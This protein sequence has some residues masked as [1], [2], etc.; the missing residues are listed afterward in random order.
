MYSR[1]HRH[2]SRDCGLIRMSQESNAALPLTNTVIVKI[3]GHSIDAQISFNYQLAPQTVIG[4][5]VIRERNKLARPV[6]KLMFTNRKETMEV[7]LASGA[8]FEAISVRGGTKIGE[9]SYSRKISIIP[10]HQPVTIV[11]K[12][13]P[14]T[15]LIFPI[16][17]FP[18][19]FGN[20][21]K[22]INHGA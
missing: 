4:E 16:L 17:N 2:I 7:V 21:S 19:I 15:E 5:M 12:E 14:L 9:D 22:Q 11:D 8:R 10:A 20:Q 18:R 6:F 13:N 3:D 1:G